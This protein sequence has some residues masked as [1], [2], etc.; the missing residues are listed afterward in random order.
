[1]VFLVNHDCDS[2]A[3]RDGHSARV[4][5]FGVLV[6]D[7]MPLDQQVAVQFAGGGDVDVEQS[8]VDVGVEDI[9]AEAFSQ[10]S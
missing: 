10:L 3:I 9:V 8:V 4:V 5:G 6:G 1:M 7:Q 2:F